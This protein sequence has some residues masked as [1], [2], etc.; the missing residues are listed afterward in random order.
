MTHPGTDGEI[1]GLAQQPDGNTIVVGDFFSYDQTS[2]NCI[3]RATSSGYLDATFDPGEGANDYISCV[4]LT[5]NNEAVIGG[6]FTSYNGILRNG[7]ALVNTNGALDLSFNP[8]QGFN[9]TVSSIALQ[10]NGQ[11]LI[12]GD[13]TVSVSY[14]HSKR[15]EQCHLPGC[16]YR[17][18]QRPQYFLQRL[19]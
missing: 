14:T 1:Y 16:I 4:V 17:G 9:G 8:G 2:R 11:V 19:F 18:Q 7:I 15:W 5:A 3:A 12:G 10:P 13:F 6:N